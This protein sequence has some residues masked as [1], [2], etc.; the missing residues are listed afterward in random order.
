M[1]SQFLIEDVGH[2][3]EFKQKSFSGFK[4]TDVIKIL[5]QSI[6]TGKLE[7]ACHWTV[8]CIVQVIP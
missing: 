8:E 3:E 4:K 1:D 2:I 6:E 7:N 5:L